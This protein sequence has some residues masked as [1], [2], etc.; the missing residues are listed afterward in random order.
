[1][2][3][4]IATKGWQGWPPPQWALPGTTASLSAGR[5]RSFMPGSWARQIVGDLSDRGA[6]AE[7]IPMRGRQN[8]ARRSKAGYAVKSGHP[9]ACL[10]TSSHRLALRGAHRPHQQMGIEQQAHRGGQ[11]PSKRSAISAS[12]I[13][14]KSLGTWHCPAS[15]PSR[16]RGA[17]AESPTSSG[18]T[19]TMGRP[20]LQIRNGCPAA[21]S[22][23]S[24][25]RWVLASC[26]LTCRIVGATKI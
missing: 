6:T 23:T 5:P 22:S 13:R 20:A 1:M 26:M 11:R 21:A 7:R 10:I 19:R 8:R 17:A 24:R 14:S 25:D 18:V 15:R 2:T 16:R 12:A 9:R 4:R 3:V